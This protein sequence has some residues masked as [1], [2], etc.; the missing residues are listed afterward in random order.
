MIPV[1]SPF[2]YP[3][4]DFLLLILF[5]ESDFIL[6]QK[7]QLLLM[8]SFGYLIVKTFLELGFSN[9]GPLMLV[10]VGAKLPE[11]T[12]TLV[13]RFCITALQYL[14]TL[15]KSHPSSDKEKR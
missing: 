11:S 10:F 14:N 12:K 9:P 6:E 15:M 8:I 1:W 2:H 7:A 3:L 13:V 4:F 5:N